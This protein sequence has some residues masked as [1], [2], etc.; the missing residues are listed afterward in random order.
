MV[1]T[2][3][4]IGC[5]D[6][7]G[8]GFTTLNDRVLYSTIRSNYIFL[9]NLENFLVGTFPWLTPFPLV[10]NTMFSYLSNSLIIHYARIKEII[11]VTVV[12]KWKSDLN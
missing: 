9:S 2:L 4:L 10:F 3:V 1:F 12:W 11:T 7:F 8:F 5:C 6:Y